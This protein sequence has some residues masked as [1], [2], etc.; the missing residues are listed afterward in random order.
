MN[1]RA[2]S[3]TLLGSAALVL[4]LAAGGPASEPDG[5]SPD[6]RSAGRVVLTS[7][8]PELS[9]WPRHDLGIDPPCADAAAE[10]RLLDERLLVGADGGLANVLVWLEHEPTERVKG[11]GTVD[12]V[13]ADCAL[14]PRVVGL[15]KGQTLRVSPGDDPTMHNAHPT[16]RMNYTSCPPMPSPLEPVTLRLKKAEPEPF[17]VRC[18][19]HPWELAWVG[20]FAHRQFAV[21]G[22]DG[23]FQL[24]EP[25]PAGTHT[26]VAWHEVLGTQR[27]EVVVAEDGAA[28]GFTIAY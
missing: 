22:P 17:R 26:L 12:M 14:A 9:P 24:P 2:R 10:G 3:A 20:V 21:T 25:L 19:V 15:V 13:F 16:P 18:D 8:A 28:P 7:P 11:E 4:A 1:V 27:V 6:A 5:S 23:R